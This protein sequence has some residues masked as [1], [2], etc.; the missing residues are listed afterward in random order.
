VKVVFKEGG[1]EDI[2]KFDGFENVDPQY[3]ICIG[4]TFLFCFESGGDDRRII[5]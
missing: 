1:K 2:M 5:F 4:T 3:W